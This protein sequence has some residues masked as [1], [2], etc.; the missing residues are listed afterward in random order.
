MDGACPV[1]NPNPPPPNNPDEPEHHSLFEEFINRN[2]DLDG[3]DEADDAAPDAD[4]PEGDDESRILFELQFPGGGPALK[5]PFGNPVMGGPLDSRLPGWPLTFDARWRRVRVRQRP[6]KLRIYRPRIGFEA[7]GGQLVIPLGARSRQQMDIIPD[8]RPGWTAIRYQ[9]GFGTAAELIEWRG[10]K[11]ALHHL[12]I[13]QREITGYIKHEDM[14]AVRRVWFTGVWLEV[15]WW[16][17]MT[18]L[19]LMLA[20]SVV[21]VAQRVPLGDVPSVTD[22]QA[23]IATLEAQVRALQSPSD[24]PNPLLPVP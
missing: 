13:N 15:S 24:A 16:V 9:A 18:L 4:R 12:R 8:V 1:V 10:N 20:L 14:P 2:L 22:L 21:V 19:A 7:Y 6:T 5:G 11:A 23:Q 17:F 3:L